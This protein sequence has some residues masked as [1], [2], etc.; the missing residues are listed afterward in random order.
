M[1]IIEE[2]KRKI[3]LD[4]VDRLNWVDFF[5]YQGGDSVEFSVILYVIS[6]VSK[7]FHLRS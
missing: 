6:C 3:T 4:W 5:Y 2:I 7:T 1:D